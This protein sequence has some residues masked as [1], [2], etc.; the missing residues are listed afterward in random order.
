M[1]KIVVIG[2]DGAT[3]DL[4]E[5]W[6]KAGN[7]PV[8]SN[9]MDQGSYGRLQSVLP[10]LSSAA[11]SSFM[12]GMNPGKHGLYDFVKR[13]P[14]SYNLKPVNHKHIRG[15]TIW[16]ILSEV[17]KKVVVM[18]VPMTYPPED[19]N[20]L[21]ISGLGTPDFKPFTYPSEFSRELLN[22]GYQVNSQV[23]FR[24][25]HEQ[26]Y[27]SEVGN[28]TDR[29]TNLA[30]R[31]MSEQ[32]WDYF[33]LVYRE[34][35]EMAHYF[36]RYMDPS[37]PQ[38]ISVRDA[39]FQDA[40]LKYY[41]SIDHSIG[42]ILQS[43][44]A[45]TNIVIMSDHGTGPFYKDVFLNEWLRQKGWLA[46]NDDNGLAGNS[47]KISAALGLTR[48]NISSSLRRLKLGRFEQWLKSVLGDRIEI[49]PV[50]SLTEF[51][52]AIDWQHTSAYSFGY[53]GQIYINLI[54]REPEGIV[55]P[56]D[57]YNRLCDDIRDAL[58]SLVDPEDGKPVVDEVVHRRQVFHGPAYDEAPDLIV[59]MRKLA[60]ITRSGYEFGNQ[61]GNLFAP[62]H[63]NQSGS[64]RMEGTLIMAGPDILQSGDKGEAATL[65]D[66]APTILYLLGCPVPNDMDG[67]VLSDWLST[68]RQVQITEGNSET[69]YQAS[70]NDELTPDEEADIVRRL[71]ELG[72]LE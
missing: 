31:L 37:H 66:L 39:P 64:H 4:I 50:S 6:A 47:R 60:Y 25:G 28:I 29:L 56:G 13:S 34:P 48:S 69:A 45:D 7:L 15:K 53:H 11:W 21:L 32:I 22:Q 38:H 24:P 1:T 10:V 41:Q 61:P 49:L 36:W 71:K 46:L 27:L 17:G 12:T 20:G 51:P 33:M 3:L 65:M 68:E 5:P 70:N 44:G 8:L 62:P 2:L 16:R 43:C 18:N 55:S 19:V 23:Q 30:L 26:D 57:E 42:Q 72:Y 63:H 54:G 40:I 14:G 59:I 35:D 58:M 9:L 67:N 52:N